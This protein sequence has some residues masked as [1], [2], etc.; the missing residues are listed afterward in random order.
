MKVEMRWWGGEQTRGSDPGVQLCG[1]LVGGLGAP[2]DPLLRGG[3]PGH[4]R[5]IISSVLNNSCVLLNII[6]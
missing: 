3:G 5:C 2:T 1:V 4:G 6:Q